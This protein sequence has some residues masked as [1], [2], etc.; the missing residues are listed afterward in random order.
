[1]N[2]NS[3]GPNHPSTNPSAHSPASRVRTG[4][5]SGSFTSA[6]TSLGRNV[7]PDFPY[8]Y[9]ST[10]RPASTPPRSFLGQLRLALRWLCPTPDTSSAVRSCLLVAT[11]G[12]LTLSSLSATMFAT[13]TAFFVPLAFIGVLWLLVCAGSLLSNLDGWDNASRLMKTSSLRSAPLGACFLLLSCTRW[14]ILPSL[15]ALVI[16][17]VRHDTEFALPWVF[18]FLSAASGIHFLRPR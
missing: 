3:S 17:S 12:S 8:E 6:S 14:L 11:L 1:M 15:A 4:P 13:P 2:I 7:A 10:S 16:I 5:S 9:H 18:L